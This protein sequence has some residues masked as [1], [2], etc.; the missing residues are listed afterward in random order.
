[1]ATLKDLKQRQSLVTKIGRVTSAIK[2]ASQAKMARARTAYQKSQEGRDDV[3]SIL[4]RMQKEW[5]ESSQK[6]PLYSP[7]CHNTPTSDAPWVVVI[8][9]SDRGLCGNFNSAIQK[10]AETF[11][12]D[13]CHMQ[14]APIHV[15]PIGCIQM[16]CHP[17]TDLYA[18]KNLRTFADLCNNTSLFIQSLV[19]AFV[20][21]RVRG[22]HIITQ[23]F[24]NVLNQEPHITQILPLI[25]PREKHSFQSSGL[26]T[27]DP[28]PQSL[29]RS[30][31]ETYFASFVSLLIKEHTLSEHS[32]RFLAMDGASEN[33]KNMGEAL[34]IQYNRLRQSKVTT[35]ILELSAA[36]YT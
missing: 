26:L 21:G 2:M 35:E 5:A 31:M 29:F 10:K 19:H 17:K 20:Q 33:A 25:L 28:C 1:M 6:F 4:W 18:F 7:L 14:P 23:K 32:A 13:I 11:L 34:A 9:S 30:L 27:Y 15:A 16:K 22:V 24:L 3:Q 12:K 36:G 8:L